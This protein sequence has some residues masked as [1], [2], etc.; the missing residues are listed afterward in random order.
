MK[1]VVAGSTGAS[2]LLGQI[3]ELFGDDLVRVE[4]IFAEELKSWH[5]FVNDVLGHMTRFRGKRLRPILLLL[6]AKACGTV[7]HDHLVL[8]AVVEMIHTATL[9]HDD[10]LDDAEIRRHVATIN[11]RWNNET[12]VLLGDYLF[13]HAF[14][15]AS[16]LESTL[17]CRLIGHSTNL[18]CEGELAQIHERGNQDLTEAQ[19]LEIIEGKTAELCAVCCQLGAHFADAGE[20]TT[21]A[22][23]EYGRC[24]GIAFQ[25]ADDLLDVLGNEGETGKSLGSDLKKQKLTLPLIRLLD[26]STPEDATEIRRL[27]ADP[28]EANRDK[29]QKFVAGSDAIEYAFAQANEFAQT[30]RQQL[31][32][33]PDSV[34]KRL[35]EEITEFATQRSW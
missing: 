18:V 15:L 5:P 28:T 33:L 20:A 25:I 34:S 10:V 11:S 27:L 23:R 35:L 1:D 9:V 24:L 19:Y 12:S 8:S 17:A 7:T 29:L 16:G 22:M 6:S 4:Q 30:A 21:A 13:T 14:H 3:D 32:E 31:A 2:G 26:Q